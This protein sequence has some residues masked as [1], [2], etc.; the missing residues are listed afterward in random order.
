MDT[1]ELIK[2]VDRK[3]ELLLKDKDELKKIILGEHG[4]G[5]LVDDLHE[6]KL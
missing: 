4:K 3:L 2:S 1:N 6:I 5:G